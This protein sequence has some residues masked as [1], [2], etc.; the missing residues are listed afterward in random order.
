[1]KEIKALIITICIVAFVVGAFMLARRIQQQVFLADCEG[2]YEVDGT[3]RYTY[4][5]SLFVVFMVCEPPVG[6]ADRQA[7]VYDFI[8]NNDIIFSLKSRVPDLYVTTINLSFVEPSIHYPIGWNEGMGGG[9]FMSEIT[10]NQIVRVLVYFD[11]QANEERWRWHFSDGADHWD[12]LI[13]AILVLV[14][15]FWPVIL[16]AVTSIWL[17]VWLILRRKQRRR[18]ATSD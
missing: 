3:F 9:I 13:G 12:I 5:R 16:V 14:I 6:E 7:I 2:I 8:Q 1:M 18:S 4:P 10:G 15:L 11:V 17:V